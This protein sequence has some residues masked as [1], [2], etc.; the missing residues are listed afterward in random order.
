[1]SIYKDLI[2][3]AISY[4]N[5]NPHIGHLYEILLADFIKRVHLLKNETILQTGTDEHGKKIEKTAEINNINVK[6]FCD[7]NSKKFKDLYDKF[8]INYDHFVRTSDIK[9]KE[10][11]KESILKASNDIYKDN[12][13]GYYNIRE[14]TFVSKLEASKTDYKDPLT[15]IP[16]EIM[17]EES[18][19]FKLSNYLNVIKKTIDNV[20]PIEYRKDL[21]NKLENGLND[22]SISRKNIKWGIELPLDKSH[23]IYVWFDAL[24]NYNSY[25]NTNGYNTYH[26]IGKDILWF[27]SVIYPAILSSCNYKLPDNILVHG[28]INDENGIKMSKSLNNVINIDDLNYKEEAIRYYL[29]KNTILGNDLSFSKNKLELDYQYLVH[30][31]GNL[32]Q[33]LYKML[34]KNQNEINELYF[35]MDIELH[36]LN[37][38]LKMEYE[39]LIDNF[40][41]NH[42]FKEYFDYIDKLNKMCNKI[43]VE[44]ELWKLNKNNQIYILTKLLII[45]NITNKLIIPVIPSKENTI[46]MFNLPLKL[47]DIKFK[48]FDLL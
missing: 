44:T 7:M 34:Y 30:S 24:L 17:N 45:L 6:D 40:I 26:L 36:N 16:Y 25:I 29:L 19:F 41:K 32:L 14:E 5:G 18:Y 33:R 9:H 47:Y 3:T 11:V 39:L 37:N 12:Y 1:M 22:L 38:E 42:N 48:M 2:T 35:N 10:F 21:I 13:E 31:Y 8:N 43:I 15:N 20:Y 27:H 28:F 23:T 46:I 4:V